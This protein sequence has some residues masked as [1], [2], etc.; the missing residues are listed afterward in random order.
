MIK[1]LDKCRI[2]CDWVPPA[3]KQRRVQVMRFQQNGNIQF[4]KIRWIGKQSRDNEEKYG[5][6]FSLD[7]LRKV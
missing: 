7:E 5:V 6:L 3:V 4:A 1:V 2:V